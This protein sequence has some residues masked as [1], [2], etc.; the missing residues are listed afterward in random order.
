MKPALT[1]MKPTLNRMKPTL[2]K[3]VG[4]VLTPVLHQ[5]VSHDVSRM[6]RP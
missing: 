1:R 5:L 2:N 6:T 3:D 4:Q